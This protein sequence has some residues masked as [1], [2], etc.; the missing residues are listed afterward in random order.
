MSNI[1][2]IGIGNPLRCDDGIGIVLLGTIIQRKKDL[3]PNI[4]FIDGGIGGMNLLHLFNRFDLVILIDAVNFDGKPGECR[5]F[6]SKDLKS[7]KIS[8]QISVHESDVLKIINM[9]RDLYEYKN[10]IF[11][12][13]VQ[14][15]DVSFGQNLSSELKKNLDFI[16]NCL[17]D[18]L[19]CLFDKLYK[20]P[21]D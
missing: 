7:N 3:P 4:E 1:G 16:N 18:E 17:Y 2:I 19:I 10:D 5:L 6:N 12:F 13:A 21:K 9:A 8:N 14:P 20:N 11:I 15:K